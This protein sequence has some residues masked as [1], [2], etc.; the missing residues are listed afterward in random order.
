M[1]F[2]AYLD[3]IEPKTS[4]EHVGSDGVHRDETDALW[5]DAA[6]TNPNRT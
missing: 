4:T 6:A 3:S 5:L 1:L 2:R